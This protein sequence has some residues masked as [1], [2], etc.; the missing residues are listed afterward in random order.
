MQVQ[1]LQSAQNIGGIMV[2]ITSFG[3][4]HG[5]AKYA[6]E[7]LENAVEKYPES[8]F[9]HQGD[10]GFT[11]TN[12]Y[13]H[14]KGTLSDIELRGYVNEVNQFLESV[15]KDMYVVL[16]NHENYPAIDEVF[17]YHGLYNN[18]INT[19]E[20]EDRVILKEEYL[21][22]D[23]NIDDVVREKITM[24]RYLYDKLKQQHYFLYN[25]SHFYH[26]IDNLVANQDDD[27]AKEGDI[28]KKMIRNDNINLFYKTLCQPGEQND[29][30]RK[31]SPFLNLLTQKE[32]DFFSSLWYYEGCIHIDPSVHEKGQLLYVDGDDRI[33][34]KYYDD[35]GF[36]ISKLFPR[37]KVIPRGHVWTW[38]KA[39]LASF[40]GAL[41]IN[42]K[43]VERMI[44]WFEEETPTYEQ[45]NRFISILPEKI[46]VLFTHDIPKEAS[47][48]LYSERD[49][50]SLA[51]SWG[52]D[53]ANENVEVTEVIQKVV[54]YCHPDRI[55]AGHH[56]KRKDIEMK[57]GS[58]INILD[59]DG[60]HIN[61]NHINFTI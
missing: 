27:Y 28:V 46:D 8:Y 61:L 26:I 33:S 19:D 18:L 2:S 22:L 41:S 47:D 38:D 54:D 31:I 30:L 15:N 52:H 43:K 13:K 9:I 34:D 51:R 3:D 48:K 56:H 25:A 40:G 55:V 59:C 4:W 20:N 42:K 17:G 58:M 57:D 49:Q 45:A 29:R 11:D 14:K 44:G 7:A 35:Q 21:C 12:I 50:R 53:V 16:G 23:E 10:F 5:N 39:T 24:Y 6:L 60:F 1:V 36:L 32:R 37:I